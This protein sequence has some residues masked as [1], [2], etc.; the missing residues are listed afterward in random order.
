M[1]HLS[2][3]ALKEDFYQTSS[4]QLIHYYETS[5]DNPVLL[6]IHGQGTSAMNYHNVLKELEKKYHVILVDCYGHGKSSHN[7]ERYNLEDLADDIMEL[8]RF[9]DA[10]M[11]MKKDG[12]I[13][14]Y[15]SKE[16]QKLGESMGFKI[17]DD[18]ETNIRFP[19]KRENALELDS[20]LQRFDEQIVKGYDLEIMDD[21][22]WITEKVN[23]LC[24]TMTSPD[25]RAG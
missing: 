19:K 13:R 24:F 22:I 20:I 7:K 11:Q 6:I 14:F 16:W 23:N 2:E 17:V 3:I 8:Q 25:C 9:V 18:F 4:N 12:H 5:N 15:T 21:E 10:Y 1:N